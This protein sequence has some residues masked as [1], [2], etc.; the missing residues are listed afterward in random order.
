MLTMHKAIRKVTAWLAAL[1]V[2]VGAVQALALTGTTAS[3]STSSAANI[4]ARA[5][6]NSKMV[7]G[8]YCEGLK[9]QVTKCVQLVL[10]KK[11][12]RV[13]GE[14]WITDVYGGA[15][16]VGLNQL[17]FQVMTT[18]GWQTRT[19]NADTGD[20]HPDRDDAV[21]AWR[22]CARNGTFQARARVYTAVD[23]KAKQWINSHPIQV[24]CAGQKVRGKKDFSTKFAY[25]WAGSKVSRNVGL[26]VRHE[27]GG[28]QA[29]GFS[30]VNTPGWSAGINHL[31]LQ[32]LQ[33]GSW[34]TLTTNHDTDKLFPRAGHPTKEDNAAT[35]FFHCAATGV[36][37]VRA[38]AHFDTNIGAPM[39]L[40]GPTQ[41]LTC[42]VG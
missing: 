10:D 29:V 5:A 37:K 9:E 32:Y 2:L 18:K 13:R 17:R 19:M 20:S 42:M 1:V 14:A 4:S 35:K 25:K 28:F 30:L 8:R 31:R 27:S 22:R 38:Q 16:T 39:W 34:R 12:S 23:G 15:Y 41:P 3:A 40:T 36:I 24:V 26:S 33:N 21:T 7:L 11:N 6:S